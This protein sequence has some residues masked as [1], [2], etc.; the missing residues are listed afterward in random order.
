M[1]EDTFGHTPYRRAFDLGDVYGVGYDE[2]R[3]ARKKVR[4]GI[5]A[6]GG[7]TQ[8]KHLPAIWRLRTIWEQ[9]EVPAVSKRDERDGK[10][11]AELY[12]CRW[13]KDYVKMLAE[14]EFDGVIIAS[15]D[16][17]HYEHTLACLER[18]LPV[19]VEKPIT[20]SLVHSET[21]CKLADEKGLVLM[22]VANKRY[23]P[24]Y[25]RAKKFIVEGPVKDPALYVA[26]FNL[27][28][29]YV[30]ILEQGTIHI[31][32]ITRYLMG[33][34][35]SVYA[36][37]VNKYDRNKLNYPVDNLSINLEFSSGAVGNVCSSA[38]ALSFKPWERVEV[39][40]NKR[41][42]A[43]EDQFELILYDEEEGPAKHW[44]PVIPNTLIFDEEFGGFM[45]MIENFCQA[46]RGVD[47]PLVTGWDGHRAY[48]INVAAHLSMHRQEVVQL[49][50]DPRSADEE[51][52]AFLT[53]K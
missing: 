34:V 1:L 44:R 32:D 49:P 31:F 26:K 19:L 9:I 36:L 7:V 17:L 13:Y 37:G 39:Y 2:E 45:G 46:I 6:A 24:P 35:T 20:R 22:T 21:M 51:G 53:K 3:A 50:L 42:L 33:D 43:V 29:D 10:K 41:W 52:R 28:Y 5:I 40:G 47:R 16:E 38:T 48:E 11:V 27:G 18:S 12:G 25:R 4:L 8:S 30:W 14:E 23:S 15:P